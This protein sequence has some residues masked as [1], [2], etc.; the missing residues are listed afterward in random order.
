MFAR[1]SIITPMPPNSYEESGYIKMLAPGSYHDFQIRSTNVRD[2]MIKA[3]QEKFPRDSIVKR[4]ISHL[5]LFDKNSLDKYCP[6]IIVLNCLAK[7][8]L[9]FTTSRIG[10]QEMTYTIDS[11]N[12]IPPEQFTKKSGWFAFF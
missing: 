8:K 1:K 6:F 4:I 2:N 12:A 3:L 11:L 10:L 7:T 5:Q 9:V